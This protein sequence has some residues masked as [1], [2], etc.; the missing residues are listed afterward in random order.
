MRHAAPAVVYLGTIPDYAE[1]EG[2]GARISGVAKASPA[3]AGG[4]E[5]GDRVIGMAGQAIKNIYDYSHAL[6]GLKVGQPVEVV[7]LRDGEERRLTI[8]PEARE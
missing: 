2:R 6:D 7:V 1:T 5:S 4:L 3:A 8:T